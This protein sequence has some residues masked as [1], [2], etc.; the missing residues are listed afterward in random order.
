MNILKRVWKGGIETLS[1]RNKYIRKQ[2]KKTEK[3]EREA[4]KR[5]KREKEINWLKNRSDVR[6]TE[7]KRKEG[8]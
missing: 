8:V 6:S 5:M 4:R 3:T 7:I 2:R 1:C